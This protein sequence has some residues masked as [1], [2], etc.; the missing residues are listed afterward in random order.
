MILLRNDETFIQANTYVLADDDARVALV[1]DA[2][3]GSAAW[4]PQALAKRGLILGAVLLTHGHADHVWDAAAVA[5]DLPVY[6]PEPDMYRLENPAEWLANPNYLLAL[7][8]MGTGEWTRPANV[9]PLPDEMLTGTFE[10]VPGVHIRAVPAP[11]HTEG[12]TV[13]LLDAVLTGDDPEG[14]GQT[15]EGPIHLMFAGDVLFKNGIG[16]TDMHGGDEYKMMA[17]LRLIT[18]VIDPH[19]HVFPGHGPQTVLVH[20]MRH[21]PYLQAAMR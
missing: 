21:S 16:R 4:V 14:L 5:G 9:L 19:T 15:V 8:R 1:V 11:G 12:S 20:E 18:Q 6:I 10:I 13:F 2:G 17:S 3:A 7:T